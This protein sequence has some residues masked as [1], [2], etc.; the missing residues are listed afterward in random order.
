MKILGI[1]AFTHDASACVT[2]ERAIL[3]FAEEER[4]N[5]QKHTTEFPHRAIE[6]CLREAKVPLSSI[7]EIAFAWN[8]LEEVVGNLG[9][10]IRHLPESRHL[11]TA[12]SDADRSFFN[13]TYSILRLKDFFRTHFPGQKIPPIRYA[14]HHLCH[15]ASA[16]YCAG[17][18]DSAVLVI[19]GRG[20][21]V[22][23]S[24][25]HGQGGK[26]TPV[27]TIKVPHSLGHLYA[28]VTSHLGFRPFHDEWRV[29]GLAGYGR[30]TMQEPF[31]QLYELDFRDGYRLNLDYFRFHVRGQA[32][33][34]SDR[35][36][37]EFG[38]ARKRDEPLENRHFDLAW[39]LQNAI[40]TVG[41]HLSKLARRI[42]GAESLS[43]AGGVALNC[44]MN[45]Q[46][47]LLAPFKNFFFQPV[48]G[49]AGTAV[50]AAALTLA[51]YREGYRPLDFGNLQLGP[52]FDDEEIEACLRRAGL[53][54]RHC[55]DV[56]AEAATYLAR[57]KIVG[58]F[59]GR[60]EA[61]PR[62]LGNRSLVASPLTAE[63]RDVLNAVV[64]KR[65]AFRPFAPSVL[66]DRAD[67][68]FDLPRGS[69][70][71]FMILS[72]MV[73][74]EKRSRIPAVTHVDGSARVQTV[75]RQSNPKYADLIESFDK[76]TGV[77]VLLNT[78][79]NENEP[80]VCTPDDAI[81]CYQRNQFDV[82]SIGNF[83]VEKA[84]P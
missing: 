46:I 55:T 19:D 34:L 78:S 29:M 16:Y 54:Y 40:E 83:I 77:P 52:A 41:L 61:G 15:A 60:M 72:A 28:A 42:T 3:A 47:A 38:P 69:N 23:T 17:H 62:A 68:Y 50:G 66:E 27:L 2:D 64:K 22:C 32:A 30:P 74:P 44:L 73:H 58:W 6:F 14:D 18:A 43:L 63:I 13:R 71:P 48:A 76:L 11:L 65:E 36:H 53:P 37:R 24:L 57:G 4:F 51:R 9:H 21:A 80:I 59:Q 56:A 31:S 1:S 10:F 7:D 25:W 82:L 81:R 39:A 49:D 84:H 75:S 67:E 12:K 70:S 5:R 35:F 26:L 79:F 20:E 33:W 8:P 45:R